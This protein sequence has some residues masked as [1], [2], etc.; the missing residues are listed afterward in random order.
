MSR[1]GVDYS[2]SRDTI[3]I[4]AMA[5]DGV[6]FACRYLRDGPT[7][8]GKALLAEEAARLIAAGIAVVSNDETTGV[9]YRGGYKGGVRDAGAA[10]AAHIAAGGPKTRPIYFTPLDHDPAG[11]SVGEW[12]LLRDYAR[13]VHDVLGTRTGWYGGT[14]MLQDFQRRALGHWWWQA[15]GWRTGWDGRLIDTEQEAQAEGWHIQQYQ[16]GVRRWNGTVDYDHALAA[17]F[18]QWGSEED[19]VSQADVI[20]ALKST[21]G[22]QVLREAA[23]L[24]SQ[25]TLRTAVAG[26]KDKAAGPYFQ[27]LARDL[28]GLKATLE[29]GI[30]VDLDVTKLTPDQLALIGSVFAGKVVITGIQA[31][32][33]GTFTVQFAPAA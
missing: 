29:A 3:D 8:T 2:Y 26:A 30:K 15:L 7:R 1:F 4:A 6:S 18:G 17:D 23:L 19:D 10:D 27:T 33:G 16:N 21:E 5:R 22:K 32:S 11:L 14:R 31:S 24:G 13:G 28:A 9:Q 12:S 20:A 25:D